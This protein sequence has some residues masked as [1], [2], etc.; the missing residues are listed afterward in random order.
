MH[1]KT[2][3]SVG[4]CDLKL[5]MLTDAVARTRLQMLRGGSFECVFF[6]FLLPQTEMKYLVTGSTNPLQLLLGK[7][8]S[9]NN[10]MPWIDSQCYFVLCS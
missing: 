7:Q 1:G 5:T 2:S 8:A 3:R 9:S 4:C 10:N 6:F